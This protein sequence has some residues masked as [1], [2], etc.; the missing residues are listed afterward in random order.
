[1]SRISGTGDQNRTT[2]ENAMPPSIENELMKP[3]D[4]VIKSFFHRSTLNNCTLNIKI[5]HPIKMQS[6]PPKKR[7]CV[8]LIAGEGDSE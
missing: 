8:L 4:P 5:N 7:R 6:K 1:M 2:T 3:W